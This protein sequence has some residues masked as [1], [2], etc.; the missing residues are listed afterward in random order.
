MSPLRTFL[1]T[2]CF[3]KAKFR[4]LLQFTSI[5]INNEAPASFSETAVS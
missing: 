3:K 4:N 2:L 1:I 5:K